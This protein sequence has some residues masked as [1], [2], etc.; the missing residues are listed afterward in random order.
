MFGQSE[1]HR[2]DV[3]VFCSGTWGKV[4]IAISRSNPQIPAPMTT[5]VKSVPVAVHTITP[6]LT[7][8]NSA[9]AIE[10]YKRTFGAQER[11]L[12][13]MP[14]GRIGH[15]ELM[16]GNSIVMV[17]DEFPLA[18]EEF[19]QLGYQAPRPRSGGPVGLAL[20]VPNVDETIERA[21][22]A[23]AIVKEAVA[24]RIWG[25]RAGTGIDPFGHKWTLLTRS[26]AVEPDEKQVRK[27]RM[28]S[29]PAH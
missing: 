25:Y 8:K 7:V 5:K 24:D 29:A 26:D 2:E 13:P 17:A 19:P 3:G 22:Q 9:A 15:A 6:H 11:Y 1:V 14:D 28:C 16:I 23:G 27:N 12:L 20:Q 21:V 4:P 10:F 18:A